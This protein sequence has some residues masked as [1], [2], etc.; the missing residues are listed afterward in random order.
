MRNITAYLAVAGLAST[1]LINFSM[2]QSNPEAQAS[3][4]RDL[5]TALR[6]DDRQLVIT[7]KLR[8]NSSEKIRLVLPNRCE[9]EGEFQLYQ[10]ALHAKIE[11]AYILISTLCLWVEIGHDET[12]NSVKIDSKFV[13]AVL[14]QFSS[15][16]FYH[17]HPGDMPDLENYFPAYKD[18]ITL[19]LINANSVWNPNIQIKH[20]LI[21]K[22]GTI[23]YKSF[24]NQK[25]RYFMN[26][27]RVVGLRG[28]EA[29]N[30]SYEY[31]RP[32]YRME[33]YMKVQNCK[34]YSGTNKQ[35]LIDCFPIRTK[36]FTLNYR[37]ITT[38]IKAE[39]TVE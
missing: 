32:K 35:K 38:A 3:D 14:D 34:S 36:A 39:V 33:Y 17:V 31:R 18:L 11:E 23:E 37:P 12:Y 5:V 6:D 25:V 7:D 30:L 2:A 26:K 10:L 24:D 19:V 1:C 8:V 22:L 20:Q 9:K 16:T 27:Y 28:Y 15:L 29:Q 4:Y 13:D 21:T